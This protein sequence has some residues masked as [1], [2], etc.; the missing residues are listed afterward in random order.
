MKKGKSIKTKKVGGAILSVLFTIICALYIYPIIM[1]VLNSF[2]QESAIQT[3][4]AFELPTAETFVGAQNF[5]NAIQSQGFLKS[6][7]Y[8]VF[9]TVSSVFLILLCCSMF[10]WYIV[11][12]N[13]LFSK[14]MYLLC[15]F[16]MVVPFQ[17]VMFTLSQTADRLSIFGLRFNTP[18]TIC[19]IYLGFGAGLAVFLFAGFIRSIPAEIEEAA[20]IDGC[21]PLQVYFRVIFPILRPTMISVGILETMW[22]WNDYLLPT[23]VLDIKKY[24]TIPMLIQYFRGSYGRVEMGPMMA[25]IVLTVLPVVIIYLLGQ[26][27]IIK[28]VMS[29]AVKG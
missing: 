5:L 21:N 26:K 18:W 10:A 27:H 1:V 28:G 9:I 29:G 25:S 14:L 6:F 17:M 12:R 24:R 4:R 8:S 16:S 15:A 22:V 11:R 23:L 19:F 3:S 20:L 2:K 7:G 13:S